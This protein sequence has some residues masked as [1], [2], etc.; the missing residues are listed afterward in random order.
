MFNGIHHQVTIVLIARSRIA[1]TDKMYPV[2][3]V[4]GSGLL[5]HLMLCNC[6]VGSSPLRSTFS[7]QIMNSL[8]LVSR[9]PSTSCIH[10][11]CCPNH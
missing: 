1:V 2:T 8:M 10:Y 9:S 11:Y 5:R 3:V 7:F 4:Y 6:V